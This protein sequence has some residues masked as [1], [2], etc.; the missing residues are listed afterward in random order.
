MN[1][2]EQAK[3]LADLLLDGKVDPKELHKG[4]ADEEEEHEMPYKKAKKTA[5]QHLTK[6]DPKYYTKTEK[7]LK[8]P[9]KAQVIGDQTTIGL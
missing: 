4:I 1:I 6:V 2:V 3:E 9:S 5:M 8:T 7:C